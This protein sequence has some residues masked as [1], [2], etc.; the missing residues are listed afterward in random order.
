[1]KIN[2]STIM[3]CISIAGFAGTV[4]LAVKET[5]KALRLLE[6]EETYKG[7]SLTKTETVFTAGPVYIPSILLGTA[8]IACMLGTNT[9]NR[10]QQA[11]LTSAYALY[12]ET[13]RNLHGVKADEEVVTEMCRKHPEYHITDMNIPDHKVIFYDDISGNSVEAYERDVID[14]EYHLNR[15][16]T[17]RGYA[18]LNEFY[19]FVGLPETEHGNRVGWSSAD[20]YSWID[21]MHTPISRDDCG[22]DVYAIIMMFEPEEDYFREWM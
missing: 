21:F 12:R 22:M 8:T 10:K 18:T 11:S 7:D 13:L 20:G 16:F 3:T 15:I 6:Q 2:K 9:M 4:I 17:L 19:K 14:A 1:M 5:P